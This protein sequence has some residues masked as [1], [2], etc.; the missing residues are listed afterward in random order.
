MRFF[1]TTSD[2]DDE[3][4]YF[5]VIAADTYVL[6]TADPESILHIT[7]TRKLSPT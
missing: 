1:S 4:P 2:I 3:P 6:P 5:G 7:S